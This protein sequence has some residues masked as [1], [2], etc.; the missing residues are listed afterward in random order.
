MSRYASIDCPVCNKPLDNGEDV[1][2]CPTCGAPYH[3]NCYLKEGK[4]IFPELH[5]EGKDWEAPKKENKENQSESNE[6]KNS[7]Y[8]TCN[9][10][11]AKNPKNGLFCNVCGNILIQNTAEN[12]DP[13][14]KGFAQGGPFPPNGMPF[15]FFVNPYGG[16]APDEEI[17]GIPAKEFSAFVGRNSQYFLPKFKEMSEKKSKSINW[18]AFFFTG[19]YFLYRKM[20]AVSIMIMLFSVILAIPS[21]IMTYQVF[22]ESF[23]YT[24][25]IYFDTSSLETLSFICN[26]LTLALRFVCG[27]FANPLYKAKAIKVINRE[28]ELNADP[29]VYLKAIAK[30]GSVA[31]K[32]ITALL[33]IY[34][35]TQVASMYLLILIGV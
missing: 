13:N 4:C 28:K 32:L 6:D 26:I 1:V 3:K 5:K 18:S 12:Q 24:G 10:C 34:L 21:G 17:D 31:L 15:S 29:E 22:C 7:D 20:Y 19:G 2:V 33:V 11:G 27:F 9:R 8:I 23:G 14:F 16:V 30:K 25:G 35:A